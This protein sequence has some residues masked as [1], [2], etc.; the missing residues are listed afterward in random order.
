VRRTKSER[1]NKKSKPCIR[2]HS[3]RKLGSLS[4]VE[5][6]TGALSKHDVSSG[7]FSRNEMKSAILKV[8]FDGSEK[9]DISK[10][11]GTV[12]ETVPLHLLRGRG[13]TF[14]PEERIGLDVISQGNIP[15]G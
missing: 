12:L 10:K 1:S 2:K 9:G 4:K 8:S 7:G 5:H 11:K 14:A 6:R 13:G 3:G 15:S